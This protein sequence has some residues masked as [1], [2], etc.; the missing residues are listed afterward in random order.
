M[1]ISVDDKELFTLSET[2]KKVIQNDIHE[3]V[4]EEDM[5]RRL[6]YIL[7]H[8]Y[9]KCMER[10]KSEWMTKLKSSGIDSIP[11]DDDK[12]AELVFERQEYKSRKQRDQLDSVI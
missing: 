5:N 8:K 11:L 10:L 7:T 1:K 12:F 4:F 9:E 6:Q 3:D 2:Q